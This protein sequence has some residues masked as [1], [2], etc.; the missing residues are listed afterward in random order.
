MVDLDN[1]TLT[2]DGQLFSLGDQVTYDNGGGSSL[3]GLVDGRDYF[4]VP[5]PPGTGSTISLAGTAAAATAIDAGTVGDSNIDVG[6]LLASF[7]QFAIG[8]V[9]DEN[10]SLAIANHGAVTGDSV[11]YNVVSGGEEVIGLTD[12]TTY[13]AIEVDENTLQLAASAAQ[14]LGTTE[15]FDGSDAGVVDTDNDTLTI[16]GHGFI[17]GDPV[18]YSAGGGTQIGGLLDG[19]AYFVIVDDANTVRLALSAADALADIN[20]DLIQVGAGT[21]HTLEAEVTAI[22]IQ[23]LAVDLNDFGSNNEH[24]LIPA[25]IDALIV[26]GDAGVDNMTLDATSLVYDAANNP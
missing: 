8:V 14:A 25:E 17:T 7:D 4:A 13:F 16:T 6:G 19:G 9:D 15:L 1:D 20:V 18:G 22:D 11:I 5:V 26:T 10:D 24:T 21:M 12:G 23:P 2:V 3:G